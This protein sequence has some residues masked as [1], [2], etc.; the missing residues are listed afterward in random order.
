MEQ[1]REK[2]EEYRQPKNVQ[3]E[4]EQ[5]RAGRQNE[6]DR[7]TL[8]PRFKSAP[9]VGIS[10]RAVLAFQGADTDQGSLEQGDHE[11]NR[12]RH[13]TPTG[14]IQGSQ[15]ENLVADGIQQSAILARQHAHSRERS[16]QDV[17][18]RGQDE[19]AHGP[20]RLMS[21]SDHR[22]HQQRSNDGEMVWMN[23]IRYNRKQRPTDRVVESDRQCFSPFYGFEKEPPG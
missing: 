16:V 14:E 17:K 13:S 7:E 4:Q 20:E 12:E 15:Y 6:G 18:N 8:R 21:Q 10:F 19:K 23:P 11:N 2:G 3:R 5:D 1:Q 9:T 22:Y